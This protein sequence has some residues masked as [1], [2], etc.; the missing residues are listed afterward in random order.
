LAS[1]T[2][3]LLRVELRREG[4]KDENFTRQIFYYCYYQGIYT[5]M[6]RAVESNLE[7]G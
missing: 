5:I 2:F 1:S 3:P 6:Q 4:E 7:K